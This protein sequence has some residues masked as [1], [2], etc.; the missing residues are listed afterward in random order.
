MRIK[1]IS[2]KNYKRF[3]DLTIAGLPATARL[4]VLVEPERNWQIVG[5][6]LVLVEEG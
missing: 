3:T 1:N 5:F 6:R 4:V 2:L